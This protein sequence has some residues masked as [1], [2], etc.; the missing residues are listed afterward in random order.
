MHVQDLLQLIRH[1]RDLEEICHGLDLLL[2]V[3]DKLTIWCGFFSAVIRCSDPWDGS[4]S[5]HGLHIAQV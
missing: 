3:K 5:Y 2:V 1:L 4:V